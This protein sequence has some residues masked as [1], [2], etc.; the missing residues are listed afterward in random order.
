VLREID[1]LLKICRWIPGLPL[2]GE[3]YLNDVSKSRKSESK[4]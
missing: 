1:V 2:C 3:W 4:W